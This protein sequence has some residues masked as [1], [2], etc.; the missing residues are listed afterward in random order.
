VRTNFGKG[1]VYKTNLLTKLIC[2]IT[3]KMAS[4]DPF[5]IGI[6]MEA[7]KPGWCDS[8]NGLP[9][10]FG[11]S[12]CETFELKRLILFIKSS[13]SQLKI[14]DDDKITLPIELAD[15]LIDLEKLVDRNLSSKS[16]KRDFIYWD[17]SYKKKEK[18]RKK[19]WFGFSGK[20]KSVY[21]GRS[22]EILDKFLLKLEVGLKKGL[23]K[24]DGMT[25]TY[26]INEVK[27]FSF[28]YKN[29]RKKFN[30][31]NQPF[32]RALSFSH[33]PIPL[34]LEGPMH[35]MRLMNRNEA[36]SLYKAIRKSDIFDRKLRMYKINEPL[37][38]IP[39]EIGRSTVF[40]PG[41]FE[42]ESIWLHMEYKYLLEILRK[43][44]YEEF[45]SDF[46]RCLVAFQDP[47]RYGRSILENSSFIA[48]SA[49]PDSE[50]HGNGFVA[51]LTG[52]TTEFLTIW[53]LMCLGE[54]PFKI[55][56]NGRLY[57]EL[58]PIIPSWLFTKEMSTSY[59]YF[60]NSVKREVRLPKDVFAFCLLGKTLVVYHNPSR[61]NT[62]GNKAAH[63]AKITLK[64][65]G[66]TIAIFN[67][68][69]IPSPFALKL[70]EGF[71]DRVDVDLS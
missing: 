25:R 45:F 43:G 36:R 49:Y 8:L 71:Y 65:N 51:R 16:K 1:E 48:S 67:G 70:R 31:D 5:G 64:K 7:G 2:I 60:T 23:S 42:N 40:T 24:K 53:L 19:V 11:S 10:I 55:D 22:K 41:W 63:P 59:F 44:L 39:L 26:Y 6:E 3:N 47:P 57:F 18:Y 58:K 56:D 13:L 29:G 12:L 69:I 27:K 38:R 14:R 28:I 17:S 9:G 32:V 20:E 66:R 54:N 52:T 35:A 50:I 68:R 37:K 33:R 15:F 62:F 30:K 61:R 46:K 21:I 34:F 4:L